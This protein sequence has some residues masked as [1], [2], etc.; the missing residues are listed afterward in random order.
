MSKAVCDRCGTSAE[1]RRAAGILTVSW[2]PDARAA[3]REMQDDPKQVPH[4][5]L[6]PSMAR[7]LAAARSLENA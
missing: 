2:A 6:C 3:C 5:S 1:V 4:L 7:A